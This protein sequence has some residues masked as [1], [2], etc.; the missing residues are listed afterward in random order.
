MPRPAPTYEDTPITSSASIPRKLRE[1]GAAL[2]KGRPDL[3][4]R[5]FSDLVN[6]ALAEWIEKHYPGLIAR[7]EKE[8]QAEIAQQPAPQ[9]AVAE[10]QSTYGPS[11]DELR[12]AEKLRRA[13]QNAA[14]KPSTRGVGAR[15]APTARTPRP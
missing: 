4:L 5:D 1:A 13:K 6:R 14:A 11:V 8:L 12:R 3:A 9:L 7:V 10:A 15:G 2:Q